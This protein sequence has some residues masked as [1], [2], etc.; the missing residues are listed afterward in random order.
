VDE[1]LT[2]NED[3]TLIK[4]A[5]KFGKFYYF[6][7]DKVYTSTRRFDKVGYMKQFIIWVWWNIIPERRKIKYP[8]IR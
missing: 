1:S 6:W 7:T 2:F 5:K 3:L 8:V 4:K